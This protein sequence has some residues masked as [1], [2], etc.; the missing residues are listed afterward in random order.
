[1]ITYYS[2]PLHTPREG[3]YVLRALAESFVPATPLIEPRLPHYL[4]STTSRA[5]VPGWKVSTHIIPAA[6]PRASTTTVPRLDLKDKIVPSDS[7]ATKQERKNRAAAIVQYIQ[8][9]RD[10][11]DWNS[12]P[13]GPPEAVL[14]NAVNRYYLS[15]ARRPEGAKAITLI[16]THA[17]GFHKEVRLNMSKHNF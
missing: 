3:S 10:T 5:L 16:V 12:H 7:S 2:Q 9:C 11:L 13:V 6:F 15:D 17:G 1:M 14:W 8:E 4:T